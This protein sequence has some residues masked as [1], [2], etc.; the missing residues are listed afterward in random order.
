MLNAKHSKII[1]VLLLLMC[2]FPFVSAPIALLAGIIFSMTSGNPFIKQTRSLTH[3]LLQLSVIGLG[4]GMNAAVALEAGRKG[5][6][7]TIA[8]ILTT[9]TL[10][11]IFSRILKIDKKTSF[12]ISAGTAIC[13]GS[14]IAA[15]APA[16]DAEDDNTSIALGVVFALN[17]VALF[18]FPVIGH[19]LGLDQSQFGLWAAIAI[20]DTSSVVGASS[21]YGKLALATATTV[22][23]TRALW[24]IPVTLI[25]G[26]VFKSG[27]KKVKVPF[28]IFAFFAAMILNSY[29]T[30]MHGVFNV[31]YI[32]SKQ[33]LVLTLFLIGANLSPE[34]LKKVGVKPLLFG[35][36]LWIIISSLSL[37]AV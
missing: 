22:K 10:G 12:L 15:V 1:F 29:F 11:Y 23:L 37:F 28:F 26:F 17:S 3:K 6:L 8:G 19:N 21:Q 34:V 35:I 5:F 32:I 25:A 13:G 9:F 18:A 4:F 2:V 27:V 30:I 33:A 31:I 14:A 16:I 36:T 24:I 7:Y 20:H